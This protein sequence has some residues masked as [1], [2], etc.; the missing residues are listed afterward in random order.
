MWRV[1][2]MIAV[3]CT[4]LAAPA[5]GRASKPLTDDDSV[6]RG[7][8]VA[9]RICA[10]CHAVGPLGA[11]PDSEAPAFGT[12]RSRHDPAGLARLLTS[13]SAA[14]HKEIPPI[15]MSP[16]EIRD[17]AAYIESVPPPSVALPP[18]RQVVRHRSTAE[19]ARQAIR[20]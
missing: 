13:I 11:G 6:T 19:P 20:T 16:Q 17:V 3:L 12:I 18:R 8:Y 9:L 2:A 4:S 14:G 10:A 5:T 7:L 15:S 1:M